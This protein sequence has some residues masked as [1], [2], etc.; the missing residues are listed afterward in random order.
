MDKNGNGRSD[1]PL[2][3]RNEF[4]ITPISEINK[5][6]LTYSLNII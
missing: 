3:D 4:V 2:A 5:V 6:N 1:Q